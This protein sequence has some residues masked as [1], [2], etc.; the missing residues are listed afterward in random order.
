MVYLHLTEVKGRSK[1]INI[2][3]SLACSL[4][5]LMLVIGFAA[6]PV[7]ATNS[8]ST[9]VPYIVENG[10][11]MYEVNPIEAAG[12]PYRAPGDDT[13]GGGELIAVSV[14]FSESVSVD[15]ETTFRIRIGTA[16]R[17][18][19]P[20]INRGDTWIFAS[21]VRSSDSDSDGVWIGD[22]TETL[23]HNDT[24][25]IQ[26]TG[27]SPVNANLTHASPGTQSN[28]KV[29][30]NATRPKVT[31][32]RIASTPEFG[33]TYVRNEPIQ[34]EAQFDRAVVVS[35]GV[36]ARLTSEAFQETVTRSANYV[37][38][39]GTAKLM[40]QHVGLLD[41]DL[42]G[43]AIPE[44]SLAQDGD[45][46]LGP[47][48]GGS[49]VD[50]SNGLLANLAS[51]GRSEN[52]KHKVD[53]RL[54]GVP[55]VIAAVQWDWE[56]DTP[57][58]SSIEMDFNIHADP[59]HF[60]EDHSL[61]L[62]LGW[63][64]IEGHRF[65]FGL[66]TDVD[67]PG[68]DGSQGKGIIFNRWGTADTSNYSRTTGDGWTEAGN[69][70]GPFISVRR[71]FDWSTGNYSVRIGKDGDDDEDG[72]WF[73][74][75]VTDKST[76]TETKVA[77]IK[78]P[79]ADGS[80]P[81][82]QTRSDVFGSLIAITGESAINATSIPV[83][84]AAVGLPDDSVGDA[85]NEATVSYSLLGR[86]ITN[87]NVS[88]DEDTGKVIMRVGGSTRKATPAGTTLTDLET[89][90]LTASTL[91]APASHDGQSA[92]TFEFRFSEDFSLSYRT[93]RDSAFTVS[94]GDVVNARR[95]DPPSNVGWEITV[96]PN[97]NG[98]VSIVLPATTDCSAT[99]AI[100]TGDGRPFSE[101]LEVAVPG[102][103]DN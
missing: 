3:T 21:F 53:V 20:M 55:E 24:D 61:V 102:P 11:Q 5:A 4:L 70:G 45:L 32:V 60:S 54:A 93:L 36:F 34:I 51:N 48:G 87:T 2:R 63:G 8:Q 43:I 69:F 40:F 10:V 13:Y 72:R 17:G 83:F 50:K 22:N 44:N 6:K 25:A 42:D 74:M 16:T 98:T 28:H 91:N 15:S 49:I 57:D 35:G 97:G 86:G 41:M 75:W 26:S 29:K 37:Q 73:G 96:E 77:A 31:N 90:Q 82:I 38:G 100:C 30:G 103:E 58:T 80:Q 19:V 18:L 9:S 88:Y 99:G 46:T 89:P 101:R 76:G 85:P 1:I 64:H 84:E 7:H 52:P 78:F 92:F 59:G 79:L 62:V 68:T 47:Q 95:L 56:T 65:A 81:T 14:E 27:D 94:G 33:D 71:S 67:K 39:S 66:R 12:W 23:D